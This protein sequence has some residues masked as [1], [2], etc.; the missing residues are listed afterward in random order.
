MGRQQGIPRGDHT[1]QRSRGGAVAG[2][3]RSAR[4]A[5]RHC[6]VAPNVN[7]QPFRAT[8]TC[9]SCCC[10]HARLSFSLTAVRSVQARSTT[11][12][13]TGQPCRPTRH[14]TRLPSHHA[15]VRTTLRPRNATGR[16]FD[17]TE[18]AP[19]PV[20][21]PGDAFLR[22]DAALFY[23]ND[24][25]I[26]EGHS[27]KMFR[28]RARLGTAQPSGYFVRVP[29][30]NGAAKRSSPRSTHPAANGSPS[31][32][33]IR[34]S[35][36]AQA[37]YSYAPR[38]RLFAIE[39]AAAAGTELIAVLSKMYSVSALSVSTNSS[40]ALNP[41]YHGGPGRAGWLGH[42]RRW[43]RHVEPPQR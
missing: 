7:E 9:A 3:D 22:I 41:R 24:I 43:R 25:R 5:S 11:G 26:L 28:S 42:E 35:R 33:R 16:P 17:R 14:P 4:L 18:D 20:L 38:W 32:S 36:P 29:M 15:T 12:R 37:T 39:V 23:G 1:G 21:G 19:M 27:R 6:P 30:S 10:A 13:R 40:G 8:H 34:L 31:R 2:A